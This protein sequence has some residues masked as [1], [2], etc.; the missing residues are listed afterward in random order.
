MSRKGAVARN[1]HETRSNCILAV[2]CC[3][4]LLRFYLSSVSVQARGLASMA[5]VSFRGHIVA[6]VVYRACKEHSTSD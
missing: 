3:F 5:K 4:V 2:I 1:S 6:T